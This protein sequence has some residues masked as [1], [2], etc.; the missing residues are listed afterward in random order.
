M[1]DASSTA[2]PAPPLTLGFASDMSLDFAV[3]TS[4]PDPS[5][6]AAVTMPDDLSLGLDP[7]TVALSADPPIVPP[8]V[9]P[10]AHA[11]P[12]RRIAPL[13]FATRIEPAASV[14]SGADA[15]TPP[16]GDSSAEDVAPLGILLVLLPLELRTRLEAGK[17]PPIV[18]LVD[19]VISPM[20]DRI[21]QRLAHASAMRASRVGQNSSKPESSTPGPDPPEAVLQVGSVLYGTRRMGGLDSADSGLPPTPPWFGPDGPV[22]SDAYAR[23]GYDSGAVQ[24]IPLKS[25]KDALVA[26]RRLAFPS[27]PTSATDWDRQDAL[28]ALRAQVMPVPAPDSSL[29]PLSY[30]GLPTPESGPAGGAAWH[31]HW[32]L[33]SDDHDSTKEGILLA[34]ALV[35]GLEL[36][37]WAQPAG[38]KKATE[39]TW[40]QPAGQAASP[41]PISGSGDE[42]RNGGESHKRKRDS[43]STQVPPTPTCFYILSLLPT[44]A[45]TSS[46]PDFSSL[47]ALAN[48]WSSN[49]GMPWARAAELL[50]KQG[51]FPCTA[52]L[53]SDASCK[54]PTTLA[55]DSP[56]ARLHLALGGYPLDRVLDASL[57]ADPN[58]LLFP[59]T[60]VTL[61][62][63]AAFTGM[64]SSTKQLGPQWGTA[65]PSL[66]G[67]AI[68]SKPNR[69]QDDTANKNDPQR[70]PATRHRQWLVC[71]SHREQEHRAVIIQAA[72]QL[73]ESYSGAISHL[74]HELK[75]ASAA[76]EPAKPEAAQQSLTGAAAGPS[77]PSASDGQSATRAVPNLPDPKAVIATLQQ[78]ATNKVEGV[79][80]PMVNSFNFLLTH[81]VPMIR[82]AMTLLQVRQM[83]IQRNIP[84]DQLPETMR[85]MNFDVVAAALTRL[86]QLHQKVVA[87]SG[88]LASGRLATMAAQQASKDDTRTTAQRAQTALFSF[89][90][91]LVN[92]DTTARNANLVLHPQFP[93]PQFANKGDATKAAHQAPSQP[94]QQAA[95][96]SS[97]PV[98]PPPT[99][100]GQSSVSAAAVSTP[101]PAQAPVANTPGTANNPSN[102]IRKREVFW[103]GSISWA[104]QDPNSKEKGARKDVAAHVTATSPADVLRA[105]LYAYLFPRKC[106]Y[107]TGAVF[108]QDGALA[109]D[110]GH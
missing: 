78:A 69:S 26:L 72:V 13:P 81:M 33:G 89:M 22:E 104:T 66:P 107:L 37:P 101:A 21:R 80:Q 110:D 20:V 12:S 23:T 96:S 7:L 109:Q 71:Y 82:S 6:V 103:A 79:T 61:L 43:H 88:A 59:R 24:T 83:A 100:A 53:N 45:G 15:L 39:P 40:L 56:A 62:A 50:A 47:P 36:L 10:V 41:A 42:H 65:F 55:K 105:D 64:T 17:P 19:K 63:S 57:P 60:G 27:S 8:A 70:S 5:A 31:E 38:F 32:A 68:W 18:S 99:Q 86:Q 75:A 74:E 30:T 85:K 98:A 35:A 48:Q 94:S 73:R 29:W 93:N 54:L 97:S 28:D 91:E 92:I 14:P 49:D 108:S 58:E 4:G 25:S 3:S 84:T 51:A 106:A 44:S 9:G 52:I 102:V 46:G 11:P 90:Q 77:A 95:A 2:P 34:E 87:V 16:L 76:A 1:G 67:P